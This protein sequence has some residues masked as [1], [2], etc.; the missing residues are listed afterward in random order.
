LSL[1]GAASAYAM[2]VASAAGLF[3]RREPEFL[4]KALV[5]E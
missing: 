3:S 2:L 5:E 4:E 1:A